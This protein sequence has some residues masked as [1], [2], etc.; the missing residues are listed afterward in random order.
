MTMATL[1]RLLAAP[2]IHHFRPL[3]TYWPLFRS[4]LVWMLVASELATSGSVMAKQERISPSSRGLSHRSCCSGV[5][6]SARISMFP[7]SGAEQ[8]R[9]SGAM[10]LRPLISAR[11][12]YSSVVSP[13]PQCG[14]GR[15]RFQSPAARACRFSSSMTGGWT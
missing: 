6:C 4:I 8:L 11:G 3:T 7:V 10:R 14:S 9:L 2:E 15:N 13:A 1:Q 5:P 12:A